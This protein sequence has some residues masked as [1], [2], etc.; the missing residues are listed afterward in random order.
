MVSGGCAILLF[1]LCITVCANDDTNSTRTI[2]STQAIIKKQTR[3][4]TTSS[5]PIIVESD[6]FR[7]ICSNASNS[8][9]MLY[10]DWNSLEYQLY[11]SC[12]SLLNDPTCQMNVSIMEYGKLINQEVQFQ[13]T[14]FWGVACVWRFLQYN[15]N[16]HDIRSVYTLIK[17]NSKIK[18]EA[19]TDDMANYLAN[20]SVTDHLN[21]NALLDKGN[22]IIYNG[23]KKYISMDECQSVANWSLVHG[24]LMYCY[25]TK[26]HLTPNVYQKYLFQTNFSL[27]QYLKELINVWEYK[28]IFQLYNETDDI[29]LDD[30]YSIYYDA[31][32]N[33]S[34]YKQQ[35]CLFRN[36]NETPYHSVDYIYSS[37]NYL[38]YVCN[39]SNVYRIEAVAN[40]TIP[41]V[42]IMNDNL[43]EFQYLQTFIFLLIFS[44]VL[45]MT[46]LKL[47]KIY[48]SSVTHHSPL[49]IC[50]LRRELKK[51]HDDANEINDE[52]V[53]GIELLPIEKEICSNK[54][55]I[56]HNA[57]VLVSNK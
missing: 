4:E 19:T 1:Y 24:V 31:I 49:P 5:T 14:C 12:L 41:T 21:N 34:T 54:M 7:Y 8:K 10:T 36:A 30:Y 47:I 50:K 40:L 17:C 55:K 29:T 22:C 46:M 9:Y 45:V 16:Q 11:S 53:Q 52:E 2:G 51:D 37:N 20:S 56:V 43:T 42:Y 13:P 27:D 32:R 35:T 39:K 26:C 28:N 33:G 15:L 6:N 44:S 48:Y 3:V 25:K 38:Q 23:R 18:I 57:S